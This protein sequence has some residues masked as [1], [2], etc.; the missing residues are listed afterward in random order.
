M[1][2][3]S[4]KALFCGRKY[5]VGNIVILGKTEGEFQF[6]RASHIIW[7]DN[8]FY[9]LIEKL[10]TNGFHVHLNAFHIAKLKENLS[11]EFSIVKVSKLLYFHPLDSFHKIQD[12]NTYV[13]L[14]YY[15]F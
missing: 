9:L 11:R 5:S 6:G 2:A 12:G 10:E 13:R 14:K 8:I 7:W 3:T 4:L 1:I 15:A